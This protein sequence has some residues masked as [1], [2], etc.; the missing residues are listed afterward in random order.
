MSPQINTATRQVKF[1]AGQYMVPGS[2]T[3]TG[4]DRLIV[5]FRYN[6]TLIEEIK[7]F[8]GARW[9]P[10]QKKWTIK[11]TQRNRFQLDYLLGNNPYARFDLPT[12]SSTRRR[13][14]STTT[15]SR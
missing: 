4:D 3:E 7:A 13:G 2:I 9:N 15:S 5:G 10:E 8:E 12:W 1:R 14:R 11:D 6:K